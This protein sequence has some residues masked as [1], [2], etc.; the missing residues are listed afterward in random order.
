MWTFLSWKFFCWSNAARYA[1]NVKCLAYLYDKLPMLCHT[2]SKHVQ[3]G[4]GQLDILGLLETD[5]LL[6][7]EY[8]IVFVFSF[9]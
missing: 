6:P 2:H 5:I 3:I 7:I 9:C 1:T 8:S 4:F